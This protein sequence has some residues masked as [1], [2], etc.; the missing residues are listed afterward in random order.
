VKS[1]RADLAAAL[2]A[3]N[4]WEQRSASTQGHAEFFL[5]IA[6]LFVPYYRRQTSVKAASKISIDAFPLNCRELVA[7]DEQRFL[8][9]LFPPQE[10]WCK[11]TS[12][13]TGQPIR[14]YRDIASAYA[15]T[16]DSYTKIFQ[17]LPQLSGTAHKGR[18]AVLLVEDHPERTNDAKIHP[19]LG[20]S[21]VRRMLI[22]ENGGVLANLK[23]WLPGGDLPLLYGR[24]RTLLRFSEYFRNGQSSL[25]P[26]VIVTSGDNLHEDMRRALRDAFGCD[27]FDA[28]VSQEGGFVALEC[29]QNCGLHVLPDRAKL[30]IIE[31]SATFKTEG[32]GELVITNL[33]NW[34]MPFIRYRTGDFAEIRSGRCCCGHDGQSITRLDGRESAS[35]TVGKRTV[36]PLSFNRVFHNPGIERFQMIQRRTGA[37]DVKIKLKPTATSPSDM[38]RS[39]T[40]QMKVLLPGE[41]VSVMQVDSF[42]D[43]HRK[44]MRYLRESV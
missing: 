13:T 20:F 16:Y 6:A 22:G 24:P 43:G 7:E 25:R 15:F 27:V 3:K 31:T 10:C 40:A 34:A 9:S 17:Q 2:H 36:S 21:V 41:T 12:G 19:G 35:F 11:T 5:A 28:Y 18:T 26:R 29:P 42:G 1:R 38:I 37:F 8:S 30:E 32:Y 33:E 23:R 44:V 4:L 39:I 14:I